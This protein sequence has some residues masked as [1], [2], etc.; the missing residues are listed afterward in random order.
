M[1][2]HS[3]SLEALW[4]LSGRGVPGGGLWGVRGILEWPVSARVSPQLGGSMR[5]VLSASDLDNT[6]GWWV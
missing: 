5:P 6:F 2:S 1:A 4:V 3:D